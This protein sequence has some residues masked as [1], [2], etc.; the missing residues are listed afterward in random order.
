MNDPF[1]PI[2]DEDVRQIAQLIETLDNSAFDY[3]EV[4]VGDL[5]V[6]LGKGD[7]P[8]QAS[9]SATASAPVAAAPA[10]TPAAATSPSGATDSR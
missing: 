4:Q 5:K 8:P 10:P 1:S 6:T 3:L 9:A 7:A 2:S